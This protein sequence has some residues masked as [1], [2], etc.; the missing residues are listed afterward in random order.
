METTCDNDHGRYF[1][2]I[3]ENFFFHCLY[4]WNKRRAEIFRIFYL[5][6]NLV[7]EKK[8]ERYEIEKIK[9]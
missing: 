5:M 9:R 4:N 2:S 1:L 3:F 6:I 8:L 7:E